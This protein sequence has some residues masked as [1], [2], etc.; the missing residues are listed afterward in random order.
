MWTRL[1]A[2]AYY[3]QK[4]QG[5][6]ADVG[7]LPTV[8]QVNESSSQQETAGRNNLEYRLLELQGKVKDLEDGRPEEI[9]HGERHCGWVA[10]A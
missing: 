10:G 3:F 8:M 4:E 7:G 9:V 6:I 2:S 1:C 5:A